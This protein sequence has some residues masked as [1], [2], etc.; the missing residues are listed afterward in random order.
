MLFYEKFWKHDCQ[1]YQTKKK[2]KE[3]QRK[4]REKEEGKKRKTNLNN[5]YATIRLKQQNT[6]KSR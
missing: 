2:G 3:W 1:L 6:G 4:R 5:N